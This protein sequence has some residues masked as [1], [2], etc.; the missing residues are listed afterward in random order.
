MQRR[1]FLAASAAA[2]LGAAVSARGGSARVQ[3]AGA[4]Q[5]IEL[6]T[7]HF[8]SPEKLKAFEDFFARAAAPALGRAGVEP[9]GAF[10]LRAKDNPTLKLA[11][12]PND[13]Y[14]LLPHRS[15]ESLMT[16]NG[17]LGADEA[18]IEAG[19][20]VLK[21][22]KD[23]PAYVRFESNLLLAFD[24]WPQVRAA[25]K[26]PGR[27]VQL[28]IYESHN[29]ER[30]QKKI[31]MFNEGG[32]I[33]IFRRCGM[34]PVFFGESVAGTKLPNLTYMLAFDDEAAQKKAWD[35]FRADAEWKKLS[36]D[37]TYK[38]AVSNITNLIL[39]PIAGSQV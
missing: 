9:V 22:P 29:E 30:A 3:G 16:M 20:A 28:R 33:E 31:Q 24:H 35:A 18:F 10:T 27:L 14:V 7:Y 25:S 32:E 19:G 34:T 4:K 1:E 15:A 37:E 38:D 17:K 23:D 6:R 26:A 11:A 21:A 12:D 36:A 8:A 39:R 5:W 2:A 13:L